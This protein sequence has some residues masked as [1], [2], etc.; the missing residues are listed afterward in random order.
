MERGRFGHLRQQP[1]PRDWVPAAPGHPIAEYLLT[2]QWR[3]SPWV[4]GHTELTKTDR[5]PGQFKVH[6]W[7]GAVTSRFIVQRFANL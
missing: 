2:K 6:G 5:P 7:L 4:W 3:S 1:R